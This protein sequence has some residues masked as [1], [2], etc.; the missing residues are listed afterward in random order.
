MIPLNIPQISFSG[1][2]T[3]LERGDQ[4]CCHVKFPEDYPIQSFL[5]QTNYFVQSPLLQT[6]FQETLYDT[7]DWQNSALISSHKSINS[8]R[9]FTIQ[10]A[11]LDDIVQVTTWQTT[12]SYADECGTILLEEIRTG[13]GKFTLFMLAIRM[14]SLQIRSSRWQRST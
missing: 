5:S 2:Y 14:G 13:L 7:L 9:E 1:I 4:M 6:N 8:I 3:L 10:P 11:Q 12:R